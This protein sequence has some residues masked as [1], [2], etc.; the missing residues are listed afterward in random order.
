[1]SGP[2][3]DC[4]QSDDFLDWM[5]LSLLP[6]CWRPLDMCYSLNSG[7]LGWRTRVSA[8]EL[9]DAVRVQFQ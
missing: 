8:A 4:P 3:L 6:Y 2:G 1:M 5:R 9:V 7:T